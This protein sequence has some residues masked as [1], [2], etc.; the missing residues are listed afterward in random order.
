MKKILIPFVLILGLSVRAYAQG[1]CTQK[2]SEAEDLYEAGRLY[3]VTKKLKEGSCLLDAK[4]GFTKEE[5][6]RAY[7]LLALVYLFMDNEPD[8]EDAVVN[9]LLVDPEHPEN[10]PN[11]PAELKLLFAKYRSKP[12]FRLGVYAGMS[13]A[14]VHSMQEYGTYNFNNEG[15][16]RDDSGTDLSK[17]YGSLL[18]FKGGLS[19]EYMVV[20]N[21]EILLRIE[22]LRAS[23]EVQAQLLS[24]GSNDDFNANSFEVSL[25]ENQQWMNFPLGLRYN[26]PLGNVTPYITGGASYGFLLKSSMTGDRAGLA[27]KFLTGLDLMELDMRNKTNWSY[28][29]GL[30]LKINI[31]RTNSLFFEASYS[32]GAANFVNGQNRYASDDLTIKMAHVDDDLTLNHLAVTVGFIKSFYNPKKYS[33]KKLKKL[34]QKK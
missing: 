34:N 15:F 24:N 6:I 8:A 23:Y 29:G 21:L 18:G 31:K 2:L 25:L 7:R 20:K 11:D 30:G 5:R 19:I 10:D 13:Y 3:E 12:I 28:F 33:E 22:Y 9:L 14:S 26:F 27:T 17:E 4:S 32:V 1:G 16:D